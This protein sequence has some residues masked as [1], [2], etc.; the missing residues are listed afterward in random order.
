MPASSPVPRSADLPIRRPAPSDASSD[1]DSLADLLT[2]HGVMDV[3]RD[4]IRSVRGGPPAR[5]VQGRSGNVSGRYPSRKMGCT[6]QYESRT[7]ELA[8]VIQSET[9]ATVIEYYDQPCHLSLNYRSR[10]GRRVVVNHTPDFLVLG[11]DFAGFVECKPAEKLQK[12][13]TESPERWVADGEGRW[14]CP[15][16]EAAAAPYGLSY[17][18]WTPANVTPAFIDNMRFLE[19]RWGGDH[20]TFAPE[21]LDRVLAR[22][23]TEAGLVLE[24]LV[25]D[26][27][28]PD[29]VHWAIFH[30]H[31]H[32]DLA[33]HFLSQPDLVR[34]FVDASA[35]AAWSAAVASATDEPA[36]S[37]DVL[38]RSVLARYS[39]ETLAVALKRYQLI[40]SAIEKGLP[41]RALT[42]PGAHSRRRWLMAYR[43]AQR[44]GGVGLVGLC[45]KFHLRGN[46]TPRLPAE[47]YAVLDKVIDEEYEDSRH[48]TATVAYAK[49]MDRC[50]QL[51]LPCV[52]YDSFLKRLKKRDPNR[53]VTR[54][55]GWKAAAAAAPAFAAHDLSVSGQGPMDIVHI[56]HTKIDLLVRVGLGADAPTARLWLTVAICAWSRCA[57]G[58]DLAFDAP[59]VPA[60]FTAVRHMFHRQ[61]CIPNRIVIDG[62]AEFHSVAFDKLCAACEID[63]LQRP[64]GR[65]KFGAVMERLFGTTNTQFLHA[66]RGNTQLLKAPRRMSRDVDPARNAIW[67]F[68][69]L[70]A[71]LHHFLFDVYSR[72]PHDG[73]D[74]MTP[75]A[76]FELGSETVGLGRPVPASPDLRFLLWPPCRRGTATV[77]SRTGIVVD[78]IRYWHPDMRASELS[79]KKV[80]VRVDPHDIGHVV[81]F[82][83]GRWVLCVAERAAEFTG[84][85]RRQLRIASL[86]LRRL[87]QGKSARK[88]IRARHLGAML[89][90]LA[91][92]EE[93]A[94]QAQRDAERREVLDRRGLQLV[95][96]AAASGEP[97]PADGAVAAPPL[98]LDEIGSGEPL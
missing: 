60:V 84:R 95:P 2:G 20:R 42:G 46:S 26:V 44:E 12:L 79:R 9:D 72:Q 14:R 50:G 27:G 36:D 47:T 5:A 16:G 76:K 67:R 85:S 63:K 96:A 17:R 10:S 80:G 53:A 78:N 15:P 22:V 11:A 39:P 37:S 82:L 90:E 8:F 69:D 3:G 33:A 65:P 70:D 40:R 59:A 7:C 35:A 21:D 55:Q 89:R 54:R 30:H 62:G 71:A 23:R 43:K 56:D 61:G 73:L 31:V 6:I 45:P 77:N 52:S 58:Y 88:A 66:L 75:H 92:T 24:E 4:L 28:D 97:H 41:A 81:S 86:E 38:A 64:P 57:V 48:I 91:E 18:V 29:L 51:G 1:F 83:R 34:V 94:L 19:G 13:V 25:H 49:A 98:D 93:G 68:A 32:V 74:G 87:R